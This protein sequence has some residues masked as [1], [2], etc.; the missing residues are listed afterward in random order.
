MSAS[1]EINSI[2]FPLNV[3]IQFYIEYSNFY[4]RGQYGG[5]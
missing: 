2:N 4:K 5:I 3:N 1:L